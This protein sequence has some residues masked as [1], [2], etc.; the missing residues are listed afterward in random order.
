[1]QPIVINYWALLVAI[2][3]DMVVGFL[4]Y[5]QALFGKKW[6]ALSGITDAKM[7]EMKTQGMGAT[8][9]WMTLGTIV[10]AYVLAHFV[11]YFSIVTV[12]GALQ[13]AFWLWL[14]FIAATELNAVLFEKKP[15][16]LYAINVFHIL[17][18]LM[19][20]SVILALWH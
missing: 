6:M 13:L 9:A 8:Y 10:T 19:V 15:V 20:M 2:V 12:T 14:G 3:A 7:E 18:G 16:A 1:M 17:V 5:S 11:G 4:W